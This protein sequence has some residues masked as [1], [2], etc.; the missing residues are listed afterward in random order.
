MEPCQPAGVEGPVEQHVR[1]LR[2]RR[3]PQWLVF[4]VGLVRRRPPDEERLSRHAVRR[5]GPRVV[6]VHLVVVPGHEPGECGV[7]GLQRRVG[8][9][10]RITIPVLLECGRLPLLVTA[11]RR[12]RG[13]RGP[14]IDV[15]AEVRDQLHV[16]TGEVLV[17]GV[18]ALFVVLAG[19]EREP[20]AVRRGVRG[21]GGARP[22]DGARFSTG[23]EAVPVPG[24]R[25]Q[26]ADFG[27]DRVA[28]VGARHGG[29]APDDVPHRLV[30]GDFPSHVHRLRTHPA[31][32][33]RI[34][35]QPRPQHHA[36]R[37]RITGSNA[38]GERV[39]GEPW[40]DQDGQA[41]NA[42]DGQPERGEP[43]QEIAT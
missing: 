39:G 27:V 36:V 18:E 7:S 13:V 11:D 15:V 42:G 2:D 31:T 23:I 12:G 1:A 29:P 20:E 38:E 41:G 5:D 8:L 26:A 16:L 14:F 34:G 32:I 33:Q 24:R 3:L 6:V 25:A 28:E 37:E 43:G 4:V 35:R 22:A 10:E 19:H 9:V 21:G 30:R 17:R 40:T